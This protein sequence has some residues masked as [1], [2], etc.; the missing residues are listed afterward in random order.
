MSALF[1]PFLALSLRYVQAVA[2]LEH[3]HH[4]HDAALPAAARAGGGGGFGG[5]VSEA[6]DAELRAVARARLRGWRLLGMCA[7]A[8]ARESPPPPRA[9]NRL[10]ARARAPFRGG[11]RVYV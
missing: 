7:R 10:G 1:S 8:R 3:L 11:T 4:R 2:L 6:D 9:S 5:G